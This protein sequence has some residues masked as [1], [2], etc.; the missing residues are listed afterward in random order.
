M[1]IGNKDGG[2]ASKKAIESMIEKWKILNYTFQEKLSVSAELLGFV[3]CGRKVVNIKRIES[4]YSV[5]VNLPS[6]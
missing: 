5:L 6:V 2:E 3:I 4:T 1:V